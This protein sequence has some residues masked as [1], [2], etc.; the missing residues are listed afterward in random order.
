MKKSWDEIQPG[1]EIG[2]LV[3]G[4]IDKMQLVKYA[5]ASGD[6]NLI[7]TDEET[8][9]QAGLPGVIAHGMLGMGFLAQLAAEI[10]GKHGFVR[11]IR[12]RFKDMVFPGDIVT[13]RAI[14][15]EKDE[16]QKTVSLEI[17]AETGEGKIVTQG[18]AVISYT[19]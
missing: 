3:K 5:G 12:V 8:A 10:V 7:H 11:H 19:K 9:R 2:R 16:D 17:T 15:K 18:S 14:A 13:C 4:P 1:E 6:Y